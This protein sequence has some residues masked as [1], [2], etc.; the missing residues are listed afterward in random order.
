MNRVAEY[1]TV[2]QAIDLLKRRDHYLMSQHTGAGTAW[3]IMPGSRRVRPSD[4]RK[5]VHRDDIVASGDA[6]LPGALPQ[7]WRAR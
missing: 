6:L 5:I 2:D 3:F 7:T 1:A 4:I